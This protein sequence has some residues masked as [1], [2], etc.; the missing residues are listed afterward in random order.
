MKKGTKPTG[1]KARRSIAD[2]K[3]DLVNVRKHNP[4][5]IGMIVDSLH[6]VGAAR[7]IVIDENDTV[8]AGNGLIEAAA[9]AGITKMQ[10]VE[11][12]GETVIAVRR[13]GLTDEQKQKLAIFDNRTAELATWDSDALQALQ[14]QGADLSAYFYPEEI[15]RL[16]E[17][18][19][20][21]QVNGEGGVEE[22][23]VSEVQDQFWISLQGP[24]IHQA[25]VLQALRA[26]T[27]NLQSVRVELGT[28]D[29]A[30]ITL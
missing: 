22:I 1:E 19:V 14:Q 2:L 6:Q 26:A 10:I 18:A 20:R 27:A 11:A 7:S 17:A 25:Q 3:P 23:D 30:S 8:L 28:I 9:E 15:D 13:R 4:R 29:N 16:G 12:D 21:E 5:N 24:L